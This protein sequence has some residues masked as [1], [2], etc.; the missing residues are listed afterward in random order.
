MKE[1]QNWKV[2][3]YFKFR[4]VRRCIRISGVAA[5]S[6]TLNLSEKASRSRGWSYSIPMG[7]ME[8]KMETT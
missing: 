4:V 7:I 8:N 2:I 1:T 6:E 3:C 5:E